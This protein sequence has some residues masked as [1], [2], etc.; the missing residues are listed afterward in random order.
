MVSDKTWEE[1]K[2]ISLLLVLY[3]FIT[4]LSIAVSVYLDYKAYGVLP[5]DYITFCLG[6]LAGALFFPVVFVIICVIGPKFMSTK[7]GRDLI[8]DVPDSKLGSLVPL[9]GDDS[10]S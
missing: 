1:V 6:M 9:D 7:D 4:V 2:A 8:D 5:Q 10:D 3:I